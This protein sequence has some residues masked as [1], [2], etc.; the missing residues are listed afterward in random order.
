VGQAVDGADD[1][2]VDAFLLTRQGVGERKV[3]REGSPR[4]AKQHGGEQDRR[5]AA[6][7]AQEDGGGGEGRQFVPGGQAAAG[8]QPA[9]AGEKGKDGAAHSFR[10]CRRG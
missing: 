4:G 1:G 7:Q 3:C 6:Q 5:S 9:G 8:L 2:G 10:F